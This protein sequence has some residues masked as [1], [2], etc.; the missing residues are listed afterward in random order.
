MELYLILIALVVSFSWNLASFLIKEGL[1]YTSPLSSLFMKALVFFLV[2]MLLLV[3]FKITNKK[4][5]P[6]KSKKALK[7]FVL[8][9]AFTFFLG[10]ISFLHM[11]KKVE[12]ISIVIFLQ[13]IFTLF[14]VSI[15]SYFF[16]GERLN[17]KQI[18]G[19]IIGL[20]G[21]AV[22]IFNSNLYKKN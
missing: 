9:V 21:T 1:Y 2:S 11:L 8:A 17:L 7:Y 13:S 12:K 18:I 4:I 5:N 14:L 22:I 16:L 20:F 19:I 6:E 15:L 10:T 3:Y